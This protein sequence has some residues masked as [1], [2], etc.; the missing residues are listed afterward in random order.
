MKVKISYIP[1]ETEDAD[2]A[3]WALRRLFPRANVRK[4]DARPPKN[5]VYLTTPSRRKDCGARGSG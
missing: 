4:S 1:E 3:L 2:A 5:C